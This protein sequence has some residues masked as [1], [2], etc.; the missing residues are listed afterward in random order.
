M[1]GPPIYDGR[2]FLTDSAASISE[3]DSSS[4]WMSTV[5]IVFSSAT[6]VILL[7]VWLQYC[8][9]RQRVGTH[10]FCKRG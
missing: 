7:L 4:G 10:Y 8:R 2:S 6:F 1:S 3:G 9:E 5:S